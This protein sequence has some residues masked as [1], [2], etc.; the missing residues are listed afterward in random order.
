MRD[1]KHNFALYYAQLEQSYAKSGKLT[2]LDPDLVQRIFKIL[3]LVP[4]EQVILFNSNY[5]V[6]AEISLI[7]KKQ[8]VL[9]QLI[10][11]EQISFKPEIVIALGMLKKENFENALYNCVELGASAILPIMF[12]KSVPNKLNQERV[13]KILIAAAEQSKNFSLPKWHDP[14][15]FAQFLQ[16]IKK[17]Q[18]NKPANKTVYIYCDIAG[19]PML[20]VIT[21]IKNGSCEKIVLIIGPEG[22]LTALEREQLLAQ[23]VFSMQLTPTILRS[24]QA[25]T[26]AL[27]ALRSLL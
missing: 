26:V 3:R 6:T 4:G 13:H 5:T 23:S 15:S 17:S 12:A 20:P 9:E 10:W 1:Q 18:A 25:V 11:Q 14:I 16:E 2:I 22:D 24:F 21:Q 8:L 27:G 7:D 19:Q